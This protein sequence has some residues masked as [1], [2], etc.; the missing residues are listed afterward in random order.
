MHPRLRKLL[1]TLVILLALP[2]TPTAHAYSVETH[3]QLIDLTWKAHIVPLLQARF[4]NITP[5]QL[6]EA[7]AYA[8]GGSVIQD[9]G[10][11]PFGD[12]LFSELTHYVR[13]GDFIDSLLRNARTPNELA[14]AIGALS[15]FLGD[16]IG[17]S[18]ATNPSVANQ[19]PSLA[20]K[21]QTDSINYEQNPHA[22]VRTEF[23]FDINEISK[24]RFAPLKYLDHVGLKVS[25]DLLARSFYETYGL[26]LN[27]ILRVERT[28]ITGYRFSVRR[29]IPRAAF[30]EN[31]LH[32]NSF[33][34]DIQNPDLDHL[35]ADL[36][37]ADADNGW[38]PF[39]RKAGP[40]TYT[41]AGIIFILPKFGPLSILSIRGPNPTA[42]QLYVKSVNDTTTALRAAL[43]NLRTPPAATGPKPLRQVD[44][45]NRDLD[46]GLKVRPGGYR[47]TDETYARLLA[48]ITKDP[49]IKVP[50]GLQQ[51][52]LDYYADPNAPI[53][54]KKNPHKWASVQT[55]LATLQTMPT[56]PE[57]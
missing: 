36:K 56:T 39:R 3:E 33:P 24:H 16:T 17:H 12:P 45:P 46:T 5:A 42:E 50:L 57:P 48:R 31:L 11:Y 21:F 2:A 53:C 47:L 43:V 55:E 28:T 34:P 23:A 7:H 35:E 38:E 9:I 13:S 29:L 22:H 18:E 49:S 6:R 37:Q 52:I 30:A 51:D 1:L 20:A 8:Y 10:Y 19:F 14:F 44:F 27:K 32:K 25:T 54:T 15:H 40:G 4:P 26:Q 41:L